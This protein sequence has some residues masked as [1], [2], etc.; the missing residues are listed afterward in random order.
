M[1][2]TLKVKGNHLNLRGNHSASTKKLWLGNTN[3][4]PFQKS[5]P[6]PTNKSFNIKPKN[7]LPNDKI[8][9]GKI[10]RNAGSCTKF[11]K[12]LFELK[13]FKKVRYIKRNE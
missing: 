10:I 6:K 7:K 8:T 1:P 2:K 3:I 12:V 11:N 13:L 5:L 9:K 4:E